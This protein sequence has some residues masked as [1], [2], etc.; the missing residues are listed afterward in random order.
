LNKILFAYIENFVMLVACH[1]LCGTQEDKLTIF[2]KTSVK[3]PQK[4]IKS[5]QT[6]RLTTSG[7]NV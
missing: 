5:L 7:T 6:F 1:I 4:Q 2:I 3:T